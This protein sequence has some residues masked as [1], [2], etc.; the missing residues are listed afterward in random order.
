MTNEEFKSA[1]KNEQLKFLSPLIKIASDMLLAG[2]LKK[3]VVRFFLNK[4]VK[5]DAA[6]NLVELAEIEAEELS[7]Y[8]FK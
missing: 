5:Q 6:E 1:T 4:G 3:N 7:H 2:V 8:K